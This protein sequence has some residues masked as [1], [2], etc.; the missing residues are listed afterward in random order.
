MH[1]KPVPPTQPQ[2]AP[3]PDSPSSE[4][5]PYETTAPNRQAP[6]PPTVNPEIAIQAQ[7]TG[8]GQSYSPVAQSKPL[9]QAPEERDPRG[10]QI[11]KSAESARGALPATLRVGTPDR[12]RTPSPRSTGGSDGRRSF[13]ANRE[14]LP[15]TLRPGPAEGAPKMQPI[16]REDTGQAAWAMHGAVDSQPPANNRPSYENEGDNS[17]DIWGDSKGHSASGQA[18]VP[19]A[20]VTG[21]R[22]SCKFDPESPR[23]QIQSS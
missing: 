19:P 14:N 12:S 9:P 13:E 18:T 8:G 23:H 4:Y 10:Q 5:S 1:R 20:N 21:E 11:R 22:R 7:S 3:Y 16:Q 2:G 6:A 15:S 17:N